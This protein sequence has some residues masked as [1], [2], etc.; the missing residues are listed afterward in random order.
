MSNEGLSAG[1][2]AAANNL[3]WD[4]RALDTAFLERPCEGTK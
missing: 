1:A 4:A 3:H 2:V